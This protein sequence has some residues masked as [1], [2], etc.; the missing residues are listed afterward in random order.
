MSTSSILLLFQAFHRVDGFSSGYGSFHQQYLIDGKIVAVGVI[1]ILPSCVSS[2]YLYYDP[3]YFFLS[4]GTYTAVRELAFT[5]YIHTL[6][7]SVEYY[8]MG[9]YIHS[10]PKMRY[11]VRIHGSILHKAKVNVPGQNGTFYYLETCYKRINVLKLV[12]EV[13]R[14]LF[15]ESVF[16]PSHYFQL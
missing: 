15:R 9:Y 6:E 4:L 8:Y 1:D 5:Q 2:V 10:C 12:K 3:D 13:K 7:P 14:P 16:K 11:K